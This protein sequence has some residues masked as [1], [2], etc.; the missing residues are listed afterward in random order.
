[1]NKAGHI[2]VTQNCIKGEY[3]SYRRWLLFG[4]ILPD[5]LFHT[6]LAGHTWEASF[7]RTI[8][9]MERLQR[10]GEMGALSCVWLGYY[11][12]F[13][14]DYF[15]HP[16]NR[17][18]RGGFVAHVIYEKRFTEYLTQSHRQE[19]DGYQVTNLNQLQ[20]ELTRL[21]E[22]YMN[23]S[24]PSF[25]YDEKYMYEAANC[26]LSYFA[27]VL[28]RNRAVLDAARMEAFSIAQD[29]LMGSRY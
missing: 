15:T 23:Q 10:A 17:N 12:H 5:L 19:E 2:F 4:S 16:H 7:Q 14:E 13:I 21:H 8:R 9:G 25:G 6:Y 22:E 29:G 18:F 28:K 20:S 27:V 11:L 26:V 24:M 3:C 1:M